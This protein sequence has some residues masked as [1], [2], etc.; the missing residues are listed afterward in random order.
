MSQ[1]PPKYK[2]GSKI[3]FGLVKTGHKGTANPVVAAWLGN[4]LM[5][6]KRIIFTI[7]GRK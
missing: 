2:L 3:N 7:R 4:L 5:I 1:L 6:V